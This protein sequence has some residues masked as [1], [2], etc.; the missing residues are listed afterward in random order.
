MIYDFDRVWDRRT[1]DSGKWNR[2]GEDVLPMWVADMDF[3]SPPAILQALQER[4]A[5]GFFGY[6]G[7]TAALSE[8]ICAR[9]A[10]EQ[11]WQVSPE[12]IVYLPGLVCGLN[13]VT[14]AV[15]NTGDSVLVN[16]PVYPPFLSAPINQGRMTQTADM[17]VSR[18][19]DSSGEILYYEPDL[20]ALQAAVTEQTRLFILCNPHNP[21]GRAFTKEELSQLGEFCLRNNL[22]ICADEIHADLL[23]D[24]TRHYSL[25]A[26]DPELAQRT[27]T[28]LAPSKTFNLPGLGLSFAVIQD[29]G[30]RATFQSA[31]AGIVPHPNVLGYVAAQAAYTECDDWLIQLRAYLTANRDFLLDFF[32]QNF[33]NVPLTAPEATYLGWI[34]FRTAFLDAGIDAA[35]A[36]YLLDAAKV[37]LGNGEDF[38]TAGSGF[39]RIN[40]GCPRAL[41]QEGLERIGN[42]LAELPEKAA[43][44]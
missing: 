4:V 17:A 26:L 11:N 10:T 37:A 34:D 6:G 3:Q 22:V 2:F 13:V 42:A 32:G 35:P 39:V 44:G 31:K 25:A 29:P 23:L 18:K 9:L 21:V 14:R 7:A 20:D 33:P 28:L 36:K 30:L 16:T 1:S 12:D 27:I 24:E 38:G 5:H 8:T 15:G 40:F 43:V 19:S 41:L